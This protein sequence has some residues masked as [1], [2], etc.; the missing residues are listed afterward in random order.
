MKKLLLFVL[1]AFG[2]SA[3]GNFQRP[4]SGSEFKNADYTEAA[5]QE[6]SPETVYVERPVYTGYVYRTVYYSTGSKYGKRHHRKECDRCHHY[7]ENH[8]KPQHRKDRR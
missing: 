2:I 7:R 3:A 5:V 4:V 6:A 8:R 1:I